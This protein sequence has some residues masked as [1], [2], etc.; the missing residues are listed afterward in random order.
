MRHR[1]FGVALVA[2]AACSSPAGPGGPAIIY[3][4]VGVADTLYNPDTVTIAAGAGVRWMN[5]GAL[6]HT[7]SADSGGAFNATLGPPGI[8]AYGYPTAG[9]SYNKVFATAGTYRYHCNFHASMH[10]VVVVIP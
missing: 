7:V 4:N 5:A 10:G 3:S 8:D 2:F 6:S 1:L 9:Q